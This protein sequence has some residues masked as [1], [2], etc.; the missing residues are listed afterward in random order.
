MLLICT[1]KYGDK[2]PASMVNRLYHSIKETNLDFKF[3]CLTEN[4]QDLDPDINVLHIEEDLR[5][6]RHWNKLRFFDPEFIGATSDDYTIVMDID[7]MFISDPSPLLNHS[8]GH[9]LLSANRWWIN[10]KK[11]CPINGGFYKFKSTNMKSV[12]DRFVEDPDRWM[13]HY[14]NTGAA[15]VGMGEQNFVCDNSPS[16]ETV[17]FEMV[18]K[19]DASIINNLCA[20]YKAATKKD[21]IVGGKINKEAILVHFCGMDNKKL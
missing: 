20:K 15:K 12:Y 21:F 4:S 13:V 3:F 1:L 17:P 6:W 16:V 10:D 8:V 11:G 9:G 19:Y 5:I 7:Q 2:Y 14:V 18:V